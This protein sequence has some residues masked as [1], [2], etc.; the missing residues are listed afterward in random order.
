MI[1]N[2]CVPVGGETAVGVVL[3]LHGGKGRMNLE[4]KKS[5]VIYSE[6]NVFL[7]GRY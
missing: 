3:G 2:S 5:F 6:E 7:G 4:N 1:E